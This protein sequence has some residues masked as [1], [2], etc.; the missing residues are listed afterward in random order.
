MHDLSETPRTAFG[1]AG[2]DLSGAALEVE[3]Q[4]LVQKV[5]RKG[6]YPRPVRGASSEAPRRTPG[7]AEP[8]F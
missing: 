3:I 7:W 2:R 6:R 5:Q 1:D 8:R 4:P